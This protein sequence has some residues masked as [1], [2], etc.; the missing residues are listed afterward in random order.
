M[1]P[2]RRRLTVGLSDPPVTTKRPGANPPNAEE[3]GLSAIFEEAR[4]GKR[5]AISCIS[6][7]HEERSPTSFDQKDSVFL[8]HPE[9]GEAEGRE[10]QDWL[11][12]QAQWTCNKGLKDVP[13][14]DCM[15]ILMVEGDFA[16]YGVYDGHGPHGHTVSEFCCKMLPKLF[17]QLVQKQGRAEVKELFME[18]FKGT[19]ES[20]ERMKGTSYLYPFWRRADI[21]TVFG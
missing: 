14:Q 21:I 18:S 16:L 15:S 6:V 13:N 5:K 17:L 20:I 1:N 8:Y 12:E 2:M 4:K 9:I 7:A 11:R 19:H 3:F 10:L